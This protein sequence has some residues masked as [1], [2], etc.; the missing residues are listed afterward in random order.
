M[1]T[2]T[3]MKLSNAVM[4]ATSVLTLGGAAHSSADGFELEEIIVTAQKRAESAQDVPIAISAISGEQ[5]RNTGAGNL[6]GLSDALPNVDIADSPGTPRIVIRGLGS[7]TGNSGFEQSVGM[8]VDGI[9]A[10]RSALFQAPFLDIARIEVLKGPQGVLFGKNSI[11]GA[12]SI[13]SNKPTEEF[14]A[15]ISTSYEFEN[16]SHEASG[17]LSGQIA[18][19]V[20][21]RL[22]VKTSEDGPYMDNVYQNKDEPK[23]DTDVVRGVVVWDANESTEVLLKLETSKFDEKG[24]NWQSFADFSVGTLPWMV[25]N[26]IPLPPA[27]AVPEASIGIA[28]AGG[29]DYKFNDNSFSDVPSRVEQ[30]ADNVTFQVTHDL[31]EHELTY[32]FGYGAYTRDHLRDNDFTISAL[33]EV[34]SEDDFDQISHELRLASP[35]GETIDYIVGLYYLD[36]QFKQDTTLDALA[37]TPLASSSISAF[38]QNTTSY[39]AFAQA[40]WNISDTWR[41]SVGLRYSKEEKE[42]SLSQLATAYKTTTSL[43]SA[44]PGAYAA[45][46]GVFGRPDFQYEDD[47]KENNLD[48]VFNVQWDYSENGMAYLSWTQASKAGGF[49]AAESSGNLTGFS[50]DQEEASSLEVGFKTELLDG[51]ARI[52]AALFRTEFDDLQV[53]AFDPTVNGFVVRNAAKAISQGIE[54][55]AIYAVTPELTIGGS[56]AYLNAEYDEFTAGCPAN[57]AEAAKL[58]CFQD[59]A[60][61]SPRLI[62]DLSGEQLDNAPEVTAALFADYS[63]ELSNGLFFGS[64]LDATYKDETS[65]DF[66]QDSNLIENDYWRINLRFSLDSA[67]EAWSVALS[68]FNVTDEQPMS[69][70]GQT[71]QT[72]GTYWANRSRGREVELAATYRFGR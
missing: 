17:F 22:A 3:P 63:T 58:S 12:V 68:L 38:D 61:A 1:K 72:P 21:G 53:S 25:T 27:A 55:E 32:I 56:A 31:G 11:A 13:I 44:A 47:L 5:I 33:A 4:F 16:D 15:E 6:E 51:R 50:F 34:Y 18:E 71:F 65:L 46:L 29:E 10:S 70:G 8:Y 69:F 9:Y 36:Q 30:D 2:F 39:S 41:S 43:Q 60:S 42:A 62:Q 19:D 24:S 52:N 45:L 26:G 23:T 54:L 67:S 66:S 49:N 7:G 37:F 57:A 14:E 48:P 64:R 59:P 20:Y 40:T 35:G 28:L